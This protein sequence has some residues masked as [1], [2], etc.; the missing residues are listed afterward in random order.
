[1]AAWYEKTAPGRARLLRSVE[2]WAPLF[3]Y[4]R[5]LKDTS[6]MTRQRVILRAEAAWRMEYSVTAATPGSSTQSAWVAHLLTAITASAFTQ[7]SARRG[8]GL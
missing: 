4:T 5:V 1:V 6:T 7:A 8:T 2:W 3:R